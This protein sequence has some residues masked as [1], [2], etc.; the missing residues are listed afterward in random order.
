MDSGGNKGHPISLISVLLT[1]LID[2]LLPKRAKL[3]LLRA[4]FNT[5]IFQDKC[6]CY[7]VL[8]QILSWFAELPLRGC[9]S[10]CP[11]CTLRQ[12]DSG[13]N[14]VTFPNITF[15]NNDRVI[16]QYHI[17]NL[18]IAIGGCH[19]YSSKGTNS[20]SSACTI[21]AASDG[22][23]QLCAIESYPN[24]QTRIPGSKRHLIAACIY[25][26][27]T[28]HITWLN[29]VLKHGGDG[30]FIQLTL[31]RPIDHNNEKIAAARM[32]T[33]SNARTILA[34]TGLSNLRNTTPLIIIAVAVTNIPA[35]MMLVVQTD[36]SANIITINKQPTATVTTVSITKNTLKITSRIV[37]QHLQDGGYE[38]RKNLHLFTVAL[39]EL[40]NAVNSIELDSKPHSA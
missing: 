32:G 1:V 6:G 30:L 22:L 2:K 36:Q 28:F 24:H 5:A 8:A 20:I 11:C 17:I 9:I 27:T 33:A 35:S 40:V 10:I 31:N 26:K 21:A 12:G 14:I 38:Y 4:V 15:L 37:S 7:C 19:F 18:L 13:Y 3:G 39:V 25:P 29:G 16:L 23:A 34:N